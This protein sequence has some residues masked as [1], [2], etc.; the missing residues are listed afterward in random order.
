MAVFET[1]DKTRSF[2]AVDPATGRH[3]AY[4]HYCDAKDVD[5]AVKA[6]HAAFPAWRALGQQMRSRL[7]KLLADEIEEHSERLAMIDA[8]DVG[9][10]ISEVRK[11][12]LTAAPT[13]TQRRCGSHVSVPC[14]VQAPIHCASMSRW[15][16]QDRPRGVA[17]YLGS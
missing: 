16:A 14:C 8:H 6:A 3:I 13:C 9:R 1:D 7:V 15:P 2:A 10:C 4:I 5:R 17:D 12:Y 11:D